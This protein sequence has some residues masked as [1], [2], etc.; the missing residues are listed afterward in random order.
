MARLPV[1]MPTQANCFP[2]IRC[3]SFLIC[4]RATVPRMMAM[5][6]GNGPRQTIE[7]IPQTMDAVAMPLF[8]GCA[9]GGGGGGCHTG[10]GCD[11]LSDE[12]F[13]VAPSFGVLGCAG[14]GAAAGGGLRDSL[15][16]SVRSAPSCG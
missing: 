13:Q 5:I 4:E 8:S 2:P 7:Q 3:G 11:C 14:R 10:S 15:S 16:E 12:R 9:Y 6:A 1:A